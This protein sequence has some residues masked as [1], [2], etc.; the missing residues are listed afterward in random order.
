MSIEK[1]IPEIITN[2]KLKGISFEKGLTENEILQIEKKFDFRFPIDYKFFLKN[3]LPVSKSFINWRLELKSNNN[4]NLESR[5]LWP[6]NGILFD[7]DNNSFWNPSW[8]E[9][10]DSLSLQK[11]VATKYYQQY[12]KLIPIYSHRYISEVPYKNRIPVFSVYQTD[13]IYYG[14]DIVDYLVREFSLKMPE[15]YKKTE[16]PEYINFWS[17]LAT[18][19]L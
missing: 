17:A 12:P 18:G 4:E 19:E 5:L 9:K 8:G 14:N 10:P 2:L 16:E 7:I 13:V 15:G 1:F 6:L 3:G 11:E